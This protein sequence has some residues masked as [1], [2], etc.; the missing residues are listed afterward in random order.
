MSTYLQRDRPNPHFV[1]Q[2]KHLLHLTSSK[3]SNAGLMNSQQGEI[4]FEDVSYVN[5]YEMNL[6]GCFHFTIMSFSGS[7]VINDV[8]VVAEAGSSSS[9]G[10][11]CSS[12]EAGIGAA[13]VKQSFHFVYLSSN[14]PQ[15]HAI[16]MGSP[17]S[18]L[19]T[20]MR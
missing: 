8:A 12:S 20:N 13:V 1:D 19:D 17:H 9:D 15:V 4:W 18:L 6:S 11:I 14:A 2:M 16:G 5:Q 7:A 10:S 3:S